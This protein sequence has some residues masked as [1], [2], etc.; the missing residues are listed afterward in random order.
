[1]KKILLL[2]IICGLT[3]LGANASYTVNY[4]NTGT[5]AYGVQGGYM[6]QSINSFGSNALFTPE[7]RMKAGQRKRQ[8][9]YEKLYY[10]GLNNRNNINVN[11]N[12][13]ANNVE[14]TQASTDNKSNTEENATA[15][16]KTT[17]ETTQPK[18]KTKSKSQPRTYTKDGVTYYK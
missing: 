1:M 3:S 9:E 6:K 16:N 15:D 13:P 2:S 8:L 11:I 4:S 7:N 12:K 17:T 10:Q 18:T 5:P 14:N